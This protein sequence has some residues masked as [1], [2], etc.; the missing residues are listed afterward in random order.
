[1]E[2]GLITLK[3]IHD[4]SGFPQS[5]YHLALTLYPLAHRSKAI[6]FDRFNVI[7]T[8]LDGTTW[9]AGK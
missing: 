1:M 3:I 5:T 8:G 2:F 6:C 9:K 7:S 4:Q